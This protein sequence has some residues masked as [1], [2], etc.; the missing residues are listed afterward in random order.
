[1]TR[2]GDR[3]RITIA[4]CLVVAILEGFDIQSAGM[5]APRLAPAL[6]LT[7]DQIGLFFSA[8]SLGMLIGAY[9]GGWLSDRAGRKS[10]LI[11]SV[12][13]FG[14]GSI[15][16]GLSAELA[17]LS[18]ARLVTGLGLGAALPALIAIVAEHNPDRARRAVAIMY[19]GTPVGGALA[20]LS[21]HLLADWRSI[22]FVGGALPVLIVPV[23]VILLTEPRDD[24]ATMTAPAGGP[25]PALFG[26]GLAARTSLLWAAFFGGMLALYL[27]LNW[28]PMLLA[29]KDF[30][31]SQIAAFQATVN[32]AGAVMV[33]LLANALDG[34]RFGAI[35]AGAFVLTAVSLCALSIARPDMATAVAIAA[36]LGSG[37]L[38][39]QSALYAVAPRIYPAA[40]RG[41]GV[42]AAVGAGR[43]GAIAGPLLAGQL[44]GA[45][46]SPAQLL[47]VVVPL[48]LVAGV[49]VFMLARATVAPARGSSGRAPRSK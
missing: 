33:L 25:L 2:S 11:A 6:G 27:L 7:P 44:L 16:T 12:L 36:F 1:M 48:I 17:M 13:V 15:A 42:G 34:P 26:N 39:A 47:Q 41:T 46:L 30:P 4:V 14:L 19:A 24:A 22:F 29:G 37:L 21:S 43:F 49:A 5:A 35:G 3:G 18:L 45:G 28:T 23:L 20:G 38:V 40:Q 9:L 8:N 32:I 10:V 31:P